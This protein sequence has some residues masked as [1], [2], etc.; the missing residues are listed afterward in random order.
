MDDTALMV[1]S[2]QRHEPVL[3]PLV[4]VSRRIGGL[5]PLAER[6]GHIQTWLRDDLSQLERAIQAGADAQEMGDS[7]LA[8]TDLATQASRYLLGR[9]GKR[10]RPLCVM[11]GARLGGR[12]LDRQVKDLA[13]ACELV[14]TATLLHDD[15]IDEGTERRGAPTARVVFGNAASVLAGDHLLVYS[16]KLVEGVGF[17]RLLG[18][19]LETISAMVTAEALQLEQRGRF[20]PD[21]EAYLEVIQG[22]T[23]GLFRWAL[24]AGGTVG[25][26]GGDE[27]A[28]LGQAGNALGLA[29]QLMDDVLDLEGDPASTGK[30]LLVDLREGKLT[31][32]FI[33]ASERDP[34]VVDAVREFVASGERSLAPDARPVLELLL[35]TDALTD[36]RRFAH[37]QGEVAL[38]ALRQLPGV[39]AR[40]AIEA[41]VAAA[42]RRER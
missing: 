31:W 13:V 28:A 16:L 11:L 41:V 4:K 37:E 30:D 2:G 8:W 9:P 20:D 12:A 17:R 38:R 7:A 19:L 39:A 25:G 10:I 22:K 21:R 29:F 24:V 14:H 33:V 23:A 34:R 40:H 6:L 26:L 35:A 42:I 5:G 32:P 18:L 27:L 3:E 36:T 1:G 15:V